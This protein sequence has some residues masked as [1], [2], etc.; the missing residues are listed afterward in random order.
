[1]RYCGQSGPA[2]GSSSHLFDSEH[3]MTIAVLGVWGRGAQ[4]RLRVGAR[5]AS[6]SAVDVPYTRSS[7][8]RI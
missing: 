4:C 8:A 7:S 1:V 6:D 5:E 3:A 2:A